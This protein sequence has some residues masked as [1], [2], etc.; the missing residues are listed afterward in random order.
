[1]H[2]QPRDCD[3]NIGQRKMLSG[4]IHGTQ[5]EWRYCVLVPDQFRETVP[6]FRD[7]LIRSREY[8]FVCSWVSGEWTNL[9]TGL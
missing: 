6:P 9:C 1:V 2:D 7:K 8:E 3:P 4:A 5:G